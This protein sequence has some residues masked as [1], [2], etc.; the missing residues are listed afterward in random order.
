[1]TP[2]ELKYSPIEKLCLERVFSIQKLKH[3]FQAH[4]V[5]L[6]SR[7][8]PIKF[9]MSKPVL[10]DRL[11]RWY[12]QF[13][14]FKIVYVP[15][16]A[17][18]GQALED[19]LADHLI[20][21][22]WELFD[23]LPDEDGM[24]IEIQPP[25]KMYFDCA[26]HREGAGTGIVFITSQGE[27]LPYSF[28]LTQWYSNNAAEYQALIFGLEI[29]VYMKQLQLQVFGDFKLVI[30]QLLGSY[31]VKKLELVLYHK[32]AKKL[33]LDVVGL[34]P[35]S[36]GGHLYILAATDYFSKWAEAV[37]LKEVK[38]ENVANFI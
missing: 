18:K 29:D 7:A 4:I 2:N 8:N 35:K 32:Y 5:R 25:W 27:V 19:F 21:D 33:G 28:T 1:M 20:P 24:V 30:N 31:E 9:V 6:V 22:D 15:Q 23:E 13:Q 14:Q 26:I 36:F 12:L 38:K 37:S 34:L 10:S 16:K 11:A 17:V 3:Y